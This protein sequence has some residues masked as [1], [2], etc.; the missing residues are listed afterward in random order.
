MRSSCT[1]SRLK[2]LFDD[3]R[4]S[5]WLQAPHLLSWHFVIIVC[6]LAKYEEKFNGISTVVSCL[7]PTAIVFQVISGDDAQ[8]NVFVMRACDFSPLRHSFFISYILKCSI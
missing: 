4:T 2:I 3:A 1:V 8:E 7:A 5:T 6:R